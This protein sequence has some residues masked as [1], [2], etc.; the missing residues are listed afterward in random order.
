LSL[1]PRLAES[2]HVNPAIESDF[3]AQQAVLVFFRIANFKATAVA[4]PSHKRYGTA[5]QG[6]NLT[7]IC[8]GSYPSAWLSSP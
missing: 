8:L 4:I 3:A 1:N 2:K 7:L 6:N 5:R